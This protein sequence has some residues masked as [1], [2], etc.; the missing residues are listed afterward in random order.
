M[1]PRRGRYDGDAMDVFKINSFND[2]GCGKCANDI[3]SID[4]DFAFQPI[5]SVRRRAVVAHEALARGPAGQPAAS[6]LGQVT[7]ENRHRFDQECRTRAIARAAALNMPASLSINFIPNAVANPMVCIQPTIRAAREQGFPLTRL[8]FEVTESERLDDAASLA[9][10]FQ[11]YRQL[12]IKTAIDDFGAGYA[13]LT[14]LARFKP[15]YIKID[16]EL[17]R[18]IDTNTNKQI[19]VQSIV[20]LCKKL[21]IVA[22][23]EGVETAAERDCL[24]RAGI[25]LMQGF[26]FA[27]PAF[28]ALSDVPAN[29]WASI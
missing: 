26:F 28:Q 9:R 22:L 24:A 23:A 5:V 8:I 20:D 21:G 11:Q 2:T 10:I 3:A 14:L 1:L 7:W 16:I 25:D 6:V 4:F 19:I 29:A 18:D 13:G 17:I 27:R 15:D 12:G